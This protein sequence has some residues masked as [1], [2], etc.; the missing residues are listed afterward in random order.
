MSLSINIHP[1]GKWA[2]VTATLWGS[3]GG[4]ALTINVFDE[5]TEGSRSIIIHY[6]GDKKE[7]A[8]LLFKLREAINTLPKTTKCDCNPDCQEIIIGE[9]DYP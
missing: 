5:S 4:N 7:A 9:I 3:G 2:R 1:T 8:N 6:N